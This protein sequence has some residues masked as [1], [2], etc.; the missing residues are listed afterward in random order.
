MSWQTVV[1]ISVCC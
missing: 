1:Q